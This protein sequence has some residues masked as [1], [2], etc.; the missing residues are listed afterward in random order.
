MLVIRREHLTETKRGIIPVRIR[1]GMLAVQYSTVHA[2]VI[3]E[4]DGKV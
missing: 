1:S 3:P 4:A 2:G